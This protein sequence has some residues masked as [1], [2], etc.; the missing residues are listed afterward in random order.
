ME[1]PD[2]EPGLQLA[3]A[4]SVVDMAAAESLL[5]LITAWAARADA[6]RNGGKG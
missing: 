2:P 5:A 1:L 6:I 3:P 4:V